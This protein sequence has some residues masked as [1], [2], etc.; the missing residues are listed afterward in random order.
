MG[1]HDRAQKARIKPRGLF[2]RLDLVIDAAQGHEN[3]LCDG[4]VP[5]LRPGPST[6]RRKVRH[7]EDEVDLLERCA[8]KVGGGARKARIKGERNACDRHLH[9]REILRACGRPHSEEDADGKRQS[10]QH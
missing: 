8:R 4:C 5:R 10:G 1:L 2:A 6:R 7:G 9:G 3:Q